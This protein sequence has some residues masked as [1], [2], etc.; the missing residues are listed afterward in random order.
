MLEILKL[1]GEI[2]KLLRKLLLTFRRRIRAIRCIPLLELGIELRKI[3]AQRDG[4]DLLWPR[5]DKDEKA[6]DDDYQYSRDPL[7]GIR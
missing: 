5:K 7:I 6:Y 2:A 4:I 1:V 3:I